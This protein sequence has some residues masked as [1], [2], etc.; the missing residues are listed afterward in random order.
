ML[1]R[2]TIF[3]LIV[4]AT[5]IAIAQKQKPTVTEFDRSLFS[6]GYYF[7]KLLD[8]DFSYKRGLFMVYNGDYNTLRVPVVFQKQLLEGLDVFTG[9]DVTTPLNSN[10][11]LLPVNP[12][13]T[14]DINVQFGGN[15][16][17]NNGTKGHLLLQQRLYQINNN[18]GL[19]S[20]L[21]TKPIN[22]NLGLKF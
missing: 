22:L 9:L 5:S 16:K 2:Q 8:N 11:I 6:K 17:F 21:T 15:I 13:S 19:S 18:N 20:S 4:F 1:R 12:F 3:I 7:A 10:N 14:F